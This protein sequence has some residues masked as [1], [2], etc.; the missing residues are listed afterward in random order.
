MRVAERVLPNRRRIA[1]MRLLTS[2]TIVMIATI[3]ITSS[4]NE[5]GIQLHCRGHRYAARARSSWCVPA[6][7]GLS[8][9]PRLRHRAEAHAGALLHMLDQQVEHQQTM[10]A[11]DICGCNLCNGV[12]RHSSRRCAGTYR[13][14]G[15]SNFI[16]FFIMLD[17][18]AIL[19]A[20]GQTDP[21]LRRKPLRRF[22]RTFLL[23][24][25]GIIGTGLLAIPALA[26]SAAYAQAEA[27]R[28]SVGLQKRLNEAWGF[29]T[30]LWRRCW[31]SQWISVR[32]I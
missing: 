1:P 6:D 5:A 28:W 25:A 24:R 8:T 13:G 27:L 4:A 7:A 20:H 3:A 17:A 15:F 29:Y 11:A 19:H 22:G 21:K 2:A 9:R 23:F 16:A 10:A 12:R 18:A 32:L 14:M 30:T 31:E 26:A